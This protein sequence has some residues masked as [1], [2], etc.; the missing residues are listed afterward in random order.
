MLFD[1]GRCLLTTLFDAIDVIWRYYM[2]VDDI[3]CRYLMQEK[4]IIS[5]WSWT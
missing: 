1:V 4:P 5:E 3:I 2:S